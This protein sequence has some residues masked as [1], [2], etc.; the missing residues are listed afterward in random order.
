VPSLDADALMAKQA[1]D[2]AAYRDKIA[3]YLLYK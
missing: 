2:L 1:A 3:P